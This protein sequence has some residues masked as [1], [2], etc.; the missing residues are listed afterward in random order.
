MSVLR[1]QRTRPATSVVNLATSPA[2]AKTLL[3]RVLD[4]VV[5]VV[6]SNLVVDPRSATRYARLSSVALDIF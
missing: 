2:I 1:D 5:V 3:L 4:V 6:V